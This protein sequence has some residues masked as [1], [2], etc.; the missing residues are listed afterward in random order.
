MLAVR[1]PR[2]LARL[3]LCTQGPLRLAIP[4]T[5]II[6]FTQIRRDHPAPAVVA[7]DVDDEELDIRLWELA[8]SG[9]RATPEYQRVST[10]ISQRLSHWDASHR[11]PA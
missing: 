1:P 2:I 7:C 3:V 5:N 8:M 9:R 10:A 4:M 6:P 11:A